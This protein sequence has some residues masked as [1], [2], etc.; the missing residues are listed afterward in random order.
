V[1]KI[2]PR[3]TQ[4]QCLH[5][6]LLLLASEPSP[7][8][9][10]G[11]LRSRQTGS[12]ISQ[13]YFVMYKR[14]RLFFTSPAETSLFQLEAR[15]RTFIDH[16]TICIFLFFAS[17]TS[18]LN[19]VVFTLTLH[20]SRR[21]TMPS[22]L[23]VTQAISRPSTKKKPSQATQLPSAATCMNRIQAISGR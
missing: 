17:C 12:G 1:Y 2:I 20:A 19:T 13:P 22:Q 14:A 18:T 21:L 6:F 9:Q 7:I 16:R 15:G 4:R 23:N 5:F 11:V 3:D 8:C 10:L